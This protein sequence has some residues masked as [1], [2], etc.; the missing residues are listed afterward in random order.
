MTSREAAASL[1]AMTYRQLNAA[2]LRVTITDIEPPIW[3]QLIV[4]LTWDLGMLHLVIQAAFNWWNSHLHE[5]QIGGLSYG[6]PD[7]IN[8]FGSEEHR[9]FSE[10][11]VRLCDFRREPGLMFIYNYDFGD[12]WNHLVEIEDFLAFDLVPRF[13]T[14]IAGAR[15]RPPE[16]VGGVSGYENFLAVMADPT[17]EDHR[18]T[19]TW[20]GGYFDPEWFDLALVDNDV[21][22][23]LKQNVRRRLHQPKP[24]RP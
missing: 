15:A 19:K 3:R 18:S 16:D 23:A 14:C 11:E 20:A 1:R 5:F 7:V 8:E 10:N 21:K 24:K 2:Q 12:N 4:P 9:A 6:D 22:K 17:H 13:A